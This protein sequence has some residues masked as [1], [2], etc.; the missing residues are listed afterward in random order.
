M[1]N[2]D[3]LEGRNL[4]KCT[5]LNLDVECVDLTCV[6]ICRELDGG[7]ACGLDDAR[8]HAGLTARVVGG[9]FFY[10]FLAESNGVSL[11]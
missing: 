6:D 7:L 1:M 8:Y 9:D 5:E 4:V 3:H 10:P 11:V 2:R